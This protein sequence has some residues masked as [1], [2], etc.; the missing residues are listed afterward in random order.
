M[1]KVS[2]LQRLAAA[3][4]RLRT[5]EQLEHARCRQDLA[6]A[7]AAR[8]HALDIV[9]GAGSA[10]EAWLVTRTD[11]PQRTTRR[12]EAARAAVMEKEATLRDREIVCRL[13]E[14]LHDEAV[15]K[16]RSVLEAR[17]LSDALERV[18][19]SRETSAGQD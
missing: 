13:V 12:V 17:E 10:D 8:K 19:E 14:R 18:I 3:Q 7:E 9:S 11:A 15:Q 16:E 1:S 5:L 2:R 4:L 6:E